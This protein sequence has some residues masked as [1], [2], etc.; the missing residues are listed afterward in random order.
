MDSRPGLQ[1]SGNIP[2]PEVS[3]MN[4]NTGVAITTC[5]LQ[6]YTRRSL[7]ELSHGSRLGTVI[8]GNTNV[9]RHQYISFSPTRGNREALIFYLPNALIIRQQTLPRSPD[10][11]LP[12]TFLDHLLRRRRLLM[13]LSLPVAIWDLL[14]RDPAIAL[15]DLQIPGTYWAFVDLR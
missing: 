1:V 12:L 4:S 9:G 6:R 14:P 7:R 11:I 5:R 10:R 8:M 15:L 13:I 3:L 2:L